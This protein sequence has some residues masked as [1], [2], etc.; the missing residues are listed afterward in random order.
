[1]RTVNLLLLIAAFHFLHP[2]VSSAF[3]DSGAGLFL[4][5]FL[6]GAAIGETALFMVAVRGR[7]RFT[8]RF[9]FDATAYFSGMY[10]AMGTF[11]R[12]EHP[13]I[14]QYVRSG[15]YRVAFLGLTVLGLL[16]M[17]SIKD[18]FRRNI[19]LIRPIAIIVV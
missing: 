14:L 9:F 15:N 17:R 4:G 18:E 11:I 6:D 3:A 2:Q 7:S 16:V 1:M 19:L 12:A 13:L 5:Y 8:S 10:V